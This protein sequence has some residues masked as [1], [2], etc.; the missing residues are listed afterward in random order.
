MVSESGEGERA[1]KE[2]L[3]TDLRLEALSCLVAGIVK[4]F[5]LVND[6]HAQSDEMR[7]LG[8]LPDF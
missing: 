7:W 3:Y 4:V 8:H 5:K 6:E 2:L 1:R